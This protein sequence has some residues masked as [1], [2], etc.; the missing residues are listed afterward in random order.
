MY[1]NRILILAP[2]PDDEVV[3]CAA[4][5]RRAKAKG[6]EIGVLF[7]TTGVPERAALWPWERRDH[8]R[9]VAQRRAEAVR[10]ADMTGARAVG[11][12]ETDARRLRLRFAE[13]RERVAA[14]VKGLGAD[15]LWVPAFEGGH[16]DHDTA[17]AIASTLGGML[18]GM[19][20]IFEFAE[21]NFAGGRVRAQAFVPPAGDE[22]VLTLTPEERELK[23]GLLAA[24]ASEAANLRHVGREREGFRPLRPYDYGRPPHPGRLF[25]ARFQWVPFRHPRV[26]FTAPADVYADLGRLTAGFG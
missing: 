12:L 6:C 26:D 11:F 22:T 24:Y 14:A 25:F 9:R 20:R 13:A 10:V 1:G 4:A 18:G 19:E 3:G 16:Q 15:T 17:N 7:L 2:H 8:G 5:I 21:Y 23:A